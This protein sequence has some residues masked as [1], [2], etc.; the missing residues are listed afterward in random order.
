MHTNFVNSGQA[1]P[2]VSIVVLTYNSAATM[3]ETL[4][5]IARQDYANIEVIICDD[6][7]ADSTVQI[8]GQWKQAQA[9]RFARISIIAGSANR[10][11]CRNL[12]A[13]YAQVQ[14]SWIKPIAGDDILEPQAISR[15]L[16][17]AQD[18][19]LAVVVSMITPFSDLPGGV[20]TWREALPSQAEQRLIAGPADALLAALLEKNVI[21]APGVFIARSALEE[22]GGVDLDFMHLEDWPLWMNMLRREKRI[23]FCAESLVGYRVSAQSISA[24]RHATEMNGDLLRDLNTFFYKYQKDSLHFWDRWD[25]SIQAMRLRQARGALRRFPRIYALTAVFRL[26]SPRFWR[27]RVLRIG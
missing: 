1:L 11:I 12:A 5:S 10:G 21:P 7:S 13:G 27:V 17:S 16:S 18:N 4:D 6:C 19:A 24:L 25:Q 3:H 20:R 22:V 8:A 2:L 9:G 15:Y 26:L 14:G 23:G